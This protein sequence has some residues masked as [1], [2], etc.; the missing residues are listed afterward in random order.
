MQ[1]NV[2][3]VIPPNLQGK[4]IVVIP[5]FV[6]YLY[7]LVL[8]LPIMVLALWTFRWLKEA[9]WIDVRSYTGPFYLTVLE[10]HSAPNY[11]MERVRVKYEK[12]MTA[13]LWVADLKEA[14]IFETHSP[15]GQVYYRDGNP[16]ITRDTIEA[17]AHGGFS[18]CE[19]S[20]EIRT[21]STN[22]IWKSS[23]TDA[24]GVCMSGSRALGAPLAVSGVQ[25]NWPDPYERY[26][27]IPLANLGNYKIFVSVK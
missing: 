20:F 18:T 27:E 21:T 23:M 1:Q 2:P 17:Q 10:V 6:L 8:I 5:R 26:A 7:L 12:D 25:T 22:T 9:I 4:R 24:A 15:G 3:P 19:M 16:D 14:G 13:S 11:F